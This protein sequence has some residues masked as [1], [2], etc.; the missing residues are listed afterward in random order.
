M[1]KLFTFILGLVFGFNSFSQ[2]INDQAVIP[3]AVT[4][5]SIMRLQ[6]TG[7]GNI[8]FSFN[9]ITSYNSGISN[10]ARYNTNFSV[11]SSVDFDVEMVAEGDNLIGEATG[12]NM[13][14][15]VIGF[16]VD[17]SGATNSATAYS[18]VTP[19]S[20]AGATSGEVDIVTPNGATHNGGASH[21]F[22]LQWQ[23]GTGSSITTIQSLNAAP[24][25][26][27]TNV[28]LT[29]TQH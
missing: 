3:L 29:L 25:R 10:S 4:L 17:I 18:A 15:A 22:I 2:A 9:S 14:L 21:N 6:V 11:A 26:Y 27:A 28:F 8:E 20:S 7:G 19:L 16:L 23:C 1:K 13:S 5:N 12:G 24:D